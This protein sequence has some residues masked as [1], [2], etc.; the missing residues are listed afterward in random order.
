MLKLSLSGELSSFMIRNHS[1]I[2]LGAYHGDSFCHGGE[3]IWPEGVQE[4]LL[5]SECEEEHK[6]AAF[7]TQSHHK[8]TELC[9]TGKSQ[10]IFLFLT[11]MLQCNIWNVW[12]KKI[13]IQLSKAFS[14]NSR[15]AFQIQKN[16]NLRLMG[17]SS[18]WAREMRSLASNWMSILGFRA[19]GNGTH[20]TKWCTYLKQTN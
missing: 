17:K 20:S 7:R 13:D 2:F 1:S 6:E 5:F 15:T 19:L 18:G 8:L 16:V 4:N 11:P 9:S 12:E 10:V 3:H 14:H